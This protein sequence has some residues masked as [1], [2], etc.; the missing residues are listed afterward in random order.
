MLVNHWLSF[1]QEK[2]KAFC[3]CESL[4]DLGTV[5]CSADSKITATKA[6]K[7][8][9]NP[10]EELEVSSVRKNTQT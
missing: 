7:Q 6:R 8:A 10:G 9:A 2:C 4:R 5:T 1:L 3:L